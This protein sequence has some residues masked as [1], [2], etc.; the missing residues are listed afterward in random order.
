[1][2]KA[3]NNYSL[4]NVKLNGPRISSFLTSSHGV[5]LGGV[6]FILLDTVFFGEASP[7]AGL[8]SDGQVLLC[9][10]GQGT[11]GGTC[12]KGDVVLNSKD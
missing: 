12:S 9:L 8:A 5:L 3:F 7:R 6:F 11:S 10:D 2:A 4:D 1:M